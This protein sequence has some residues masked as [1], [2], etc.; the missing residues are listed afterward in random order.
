MNLPLNNIR[1]EYGQES[2]EEN[3][4]PSRPYSLFAQWLSQALESGESEPTAF[5]LSTCGKKGRPSSRVV[6][7]KVAD[8]SGMVFFTNYQSRKAVEISENPWVSLNFFWP[9]LER[10]IRVEGYMQKVS[11]EESHEYFM[12]RPYE[13]R[14]AARISPQSQRLDSREAL[15]RRFKEESE[16]F[17][18]DVPLPDHWGGFRVIPDRFEFWQGGRYR[19]HDRLLYLREDEDWSTCRLA[20]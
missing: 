8:E 17:P 9:S 14:I 15:E 5:V 4:P 13:S 16:R 2:M 1:R 10:Q 12:S 6:L 18:A 7:L 19:L 11:R 20:P 3:K